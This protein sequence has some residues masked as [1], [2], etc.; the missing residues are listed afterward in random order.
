MDIDTSKAALVALRQVVVYYAAMASSSGARGK[1][2][3]VE[4]P[5]ALV[6]ALSQDAQLYIDVCVRVRVRV[7]VRLGLGSARMRS[8]TLTYVLGLGLGLG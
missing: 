5:R 3:S 8:S 7:R 4:T 2:A 1:D 6:R